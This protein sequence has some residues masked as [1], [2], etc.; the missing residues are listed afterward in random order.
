MYPL[1]SEFNLNHQTKKDTP[2]TH[3]KKGRESYKLDQRE[4]E[5]QDMLNEGLFF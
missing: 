3:T 2:C 5:G 4:K 1:W